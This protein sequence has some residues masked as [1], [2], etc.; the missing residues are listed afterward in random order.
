MDKGINTRRYC[1][2]L[3]TPQ[4]QTVPAER[5]RLQ[6]GPKEVKKPKVLVRGGGLGGQGLVMREEER[7]A[8]ENTV[9][10]TPAPLGVSTSW[11]DA[12]IWTALPPTVDLQE[13]CLWK[14]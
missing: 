11:D 6:I 4:M 13:A 14:E 12:L 10:L 5:E 1:A 9:E 2:S 8:F 3:K 7:V